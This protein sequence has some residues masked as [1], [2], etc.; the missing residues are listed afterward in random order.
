M[1]KVYKFDYLVYSMKVRNVILGLGILII[2]G[3]VLSQGIQTFYPEPEFEEFCNVPEN[4]YNK[5]SEDCE[6]SQSLVTKENSCEK[7]GGI[8]VQEYDNAGCVIDGYCNDC[9][10]GYDNA[11]DDYSQKVFIFSLIIGFFTLILGIFILKVEP[12]GSA[13][14]ASG[15][16]AIFYGTLWNWRNF[17]NGWRF[18][19][20]LT[21]L[22]FLI[23]IG[24]KFGYKK[25]RK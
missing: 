25:K 5:F 10:I 1:N 11:L 14:L 2:Y 3:L 17:S 12:V 19:L 20:L 4:S 6:F 9:L 7:I 15:I 13:L 23:W 8:F 21:V 18:L 16:W 22:L 24:M